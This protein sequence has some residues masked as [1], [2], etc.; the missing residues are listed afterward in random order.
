MKRKP[1]ALKGALA[2]EQLSEDVKE[3]HEK[4]FS[5]NPKDF[6]ELLQYCKENDITISKVQGAISQ[7]L[8]ITPTSV[9]KDKILTIMD[10]EKEKSQSFEI[11]YKLS[12]KDVD[13][14]V[15]QS[16]ETLKEACNFLN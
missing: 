12:S 15:R 4:Y 2:Y 14:I 5:D 16:K 11:G 13:E 7:I 10:K 8:S 3:I 1:G 6:I 9:S